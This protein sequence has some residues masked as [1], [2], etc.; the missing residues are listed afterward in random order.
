MSSG[1]RFDADV[2]LPEVAVPPGRIILTG[3]PTLRPDLP[4][5]LSCGAMATDGLALTA[6]LP[7]L[8][9]AGLKRVR[10]GFHAARADAHDWVAGRSGC[11]KRVLRGIRASQDAGLVV[12]AEVLLTRPTA[13]LLV[14][15]VQALGAMGVGR[16]LVRR[17][18]R[19]DVTWAA[20]WGQIDFSRAVRAAPD[21][22]VHDFPRCVLGDAAA[23]SV[24]WADE[25]EIGPLARSG[26]YADGCGDC[27]CDG[28]DADY[29]G[30]F[31]RTELPDAPPSPTLVLDG[32]SRGL[33]QQLVRL[34][35]HHTTIQ[36]D[37]DLGRPEA[38]ELLRD[39]ARLFESVQ[40]HT[41]GSTE[42]WSK[43]QR[44]ALRG[45]NLLP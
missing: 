38:S 24:P 37:V 29:V 2:T 9:R 15:T 22:T 13:P 33:R 43:R 12:E 25:P 21:V 19:V 32:P 45:V 39:C 35:Q 42:G 5:L 40:A 30:L 7:G 8:M 31:G 3:E 26:E 34:A 44:D 4:E 6:A 23:W 14:E 28:P 17:H 1:G 11:A 41:T 16:V 10:I 18:P 36:V 27:T 20:R